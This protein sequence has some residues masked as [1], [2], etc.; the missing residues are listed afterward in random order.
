MACHGD[1]MGEQVAFQRT[2]PPQGHHTHTT[3]ASVTTWYLLSQ[4]FIV[5]ITYVRGC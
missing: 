5:K 2:P 4:G 3:E 1:P